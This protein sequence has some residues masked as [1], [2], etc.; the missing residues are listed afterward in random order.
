MVAVRALMLDLPP[1]IDWV[2]GV[3]ADAGVEDVDAMGLALSRWPRSLHEWEGIRFRSEVGLSRPRSAQAHPDSWWTTR[4]RRGHRRALDA[5]PLG[6]PR[7]TCVC[8]GALGPVTLDHIV[9]LCQGGADAWWN[10]A[11][12]CEP[13]HYSACKVEVPELPPPLA[14]CVNVEGYLRGRVVGWWQVSDAEPPIDWW[15]VGYTSL[16]EKGFEARMGAS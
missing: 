14:W 16:G 12:V 6:R 3:L 13:C 2:P 7:D 11:Q 5:S 15:Q 8:C 9:P 10:L 4:D 1:G